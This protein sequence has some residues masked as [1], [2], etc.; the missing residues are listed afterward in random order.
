M[1]SES[2]LDSIFPSLQFQIYGFRTPYRLDRNDRGG[3]ILLFV[4]ESVITRLLSRHSFPHDFE[5]LF[6]E[7][8]FRKKKRILFCCYNPHKNL[9]NYQLQE[10][11]KG[12]QIYSSNYDD[13]LLMVDFNAEVSENN[14]Q[15]ACYKSPT[16]SSCIEVFLTNSPN[17]FQESTVVEAALSDFHKLIVTVMKSYSPKRTPNIFT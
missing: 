15:W 11:A 7:L 14:Q 2:K 13:I 8:N 1:I 16:N 10:L 5:I 6:I 3:G 12:I 4:R 17:S 9:I